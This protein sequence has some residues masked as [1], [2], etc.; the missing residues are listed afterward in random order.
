MKIH[1]N[2]RKSQTK[3]M[4]CKPK[5]SDEHQMKSKDIKK[6]DEKQRKSMNINE[7]QENQRKCMKTLGKSMKILGNQ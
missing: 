1:G 3:K 7:K 2:I 6:N 4:Q 5:E